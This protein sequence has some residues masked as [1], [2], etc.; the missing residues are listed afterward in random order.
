MASVHC[1]EFLKKRGR[2]SRKVPLMVA[3]EAASGRWRRKGRAALVGGRE[4]G[5]E[6]NVLQTEEEEDVGQKREKARVRLIEEE[7]D[8]GVGT[9]RCCFAMRA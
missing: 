6:A 3:R 2:E 8:K 5:Q 1:E 9:K 4:K 7:E